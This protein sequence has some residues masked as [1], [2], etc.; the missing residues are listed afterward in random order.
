MGKGKMKD[1][2]T[3]KDML[4]RTE[5]PVKALSHDRMVLAHDQVVF[6]N[7]LKPRCVAVARYRLRV[8]APMSQK[9]AMRIRRFLYL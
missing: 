9:S 4:Q 1:L 7:F 3:K 6:G 2:K 8:S 5:E